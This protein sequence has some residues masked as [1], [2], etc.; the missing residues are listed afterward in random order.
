MVRKASSP[1]APPRVQD[2]AHP[3][4]HR[5]AGCSGSP[6]RGAS[7][8]PRQPHTTTGSQLGTTGAGKSWGTSGMQESSA[9]L[10]GCFLGSPRGSSFTGWSDHFR[11]ILA[12]R[13]HS[14]FRI[15]QNLRLVFWPFLH[16]Q[17][18]NPL[19]S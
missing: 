19:G 12:S 17:L 15:L 4:E 16:L 8:P 3:W 1:P 7:E 9:A 13:E 18:G 5:D 10:P 11:V 14:D 2:P 6:S